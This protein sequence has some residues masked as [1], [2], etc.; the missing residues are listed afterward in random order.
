MCNKLKM[1]ETNKKWNVTYVGNDSVK[2][3]NLQK[4]LNTLFPRENDKIG[5]ARVVTIS[6]NS[7]HLF[8]KKNHKYLRT[9]A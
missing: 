3:E 5:Q 1:E 2:N 9:H 8:F 7:K 6:I 4:L